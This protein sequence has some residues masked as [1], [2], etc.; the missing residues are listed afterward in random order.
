[1]H[2]D[3]CKDAVQGIPGYTASDADRIL[4][5]SQIVKKNN[6]KLLQLK[7]VFNSKWI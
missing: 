2:D 6:L 3:L 5:A 1:M 7:K 4:T